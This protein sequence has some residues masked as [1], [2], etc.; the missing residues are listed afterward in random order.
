MIS[1]PLFLIS[2][3]ISALIAF[4]T[5]QVIVESSIILFKMKR[6]RTRL[7]LRLFPFLS[8]LLDFLLNSFSI[9]HWLNPLNCHSCVQK[10]ILPLFFPELKNYLYSNE[11]SLITYLGL[12]ISHTIF[13]I[14]FVLF[15][16]ATVYFISYVLLEGWLI[17]RALRSMM[18]R[19]EICSRPIKNSVLA[20]ALQS[21]HVKIFSSEQ[22][23]I[24]MATY[25]KAIFIPSSIVKE[26]PQR[27][28]EAIVAHELEH[29]LW[30]DQPVRLLTHLISKLFWWVPTG[31]WQ[32]K[33]E[34]DQEIACDQSLSKYGFNQEFLASALIKVSRSAKGKTHQALCYLSDEKHPT[35][36]RLQILLGIPSTYSNSCKWVN[37]AVITIGSLIALVCTLWT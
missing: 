19:E 20:N 31:S 2:T 35:L 9:G 7:F 11:I 10:L 18:K 23:T 5:V 34:L 14:I 22:V 37:C 8:L 1:N 29:V 26:F 4:V 33:L 16:V 32:K 17:L 24:P 25:F 6:G 36:R 13:S 3:L 27:E 30:R 15:W 12:G 28:F 21:S